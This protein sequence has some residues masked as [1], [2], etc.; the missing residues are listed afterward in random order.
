M[1]PT[2]TRG[3]SLVEVLVA[4][5]LVAGAV[6]MLA[7]VGILG[8]VQTGTSHDAG[9][10]LTLAQGKLDELRAATWAYDGTGAPVAG[11]ELALTSTLTPL[12]GGAATSEFLNRF[13]QPVGSQTLAAFERRWSVSLYDA[14]DPDTLLLQ[15]CVDTVPRGVGHCLVTVRARQP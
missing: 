12:G 7:S 6:A 10:A 1:L 5:V 14:A 9:L 11:V 3:F 13:G 2:S 15:A 8:L 4:M